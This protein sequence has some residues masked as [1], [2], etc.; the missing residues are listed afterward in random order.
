M[1]LK[2]MVGLFQRCRIQ[3]SNSVAGGGDF[4]RSG[5][6]RSFGSAA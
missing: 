2:L 3:T 6:G 5:S 4:H 1:S